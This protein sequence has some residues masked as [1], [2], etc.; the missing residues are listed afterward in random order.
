MYIVLSILAELFFVSLL[1]F[2]FYR[3]KPRFGLAPLYILLGANQYFQTI[4]A[5]SFYIKLFGELSI[6]PGNIILFSSSLFAILFIYIKE[7]ERST[8]VL[9]MGI[10]LANL[11]IT[12][13]ASITHLQETVM[14]DIINSS[15]TVPDFFNT[16]FRIFFVGNVTLIMDAFIMVILYEFFFTKVRRLKLFTR[17]LITMLVVLNFDAVV[18]VLGS[19]WGSTDLWNQVASQLIGK[20]VVAMFFATVLWLYLRYLDNDRKNYDEYPRK[21]GNEDIFSILTYKG[22]LEKLQ[23]EKTISDEQLQKSITDKTEELQNSVRRFIILSSVHEL[24]MDKSSSAEQAREFLKKIRE[25]FEID[26]CTIHLLKD[27]EL[28]MLSNVGIEKNE[29]EEILVST[30]PYFKEI[31][32]KKKCL[33]IEDTRKNQDWVK[34]REMGLIKFNYLSCLG[35]PLLSGNKVIGVIKLYSRIVKRVFTAIE[36]EHFQS[37]ARQV[38]HT[39]ENAQLYEQNEKHKEV[40]VRQIIAR[41]KAVEET[42]KSIQRFELIGKAANDAVWEWNLE[43]SEFWSN[44]IHMN[45]YGLTKADPEPGDGEWKRRL[46]DEDRERMLQTIDNA[47]ASDV[48]SFDA[49]YRLYTENKGWRTIYGRNYIERN[50]EGKAI[51]M[52]GSMMDITERKKAETE[53]QKLATIVQRSPEFIGIAGLDAK[54]IYLN[55]GGK[56]M[57]GLDADIT[58]TSMWDYFAPPDLEIFQTKALP[59]I[60]KA[61]RWVGDINLKNFQT[62]E[63]IPVWMDI[64][65]IFHQQ[66][67]EPIA[68][69]T[70]TTDITERKKT[71]AAMLQVNERNELIS[72]ATNDA[73]WDW[74]LTTNNV[75]WN[76]GVTQLFGHI[77]N[78]NITTPDWWLENIH[79]DEREKVE[80]FFFD[81]VNGKADFWEDEYRF[82]C[83]DGTYKNVYDRGLVRRDE[84]GKAF[85]ML[86]AMMDITDRKKAEEEL[87]TTNERLLFHLDNSPLG[88]IE[89]DKNF[90]VR[91][92]SKRTEEIFGWTEKEFIEKQKNGFS[93][94]YEE[95]ISELTVIAKQLMEGTVARNHIIHRNYTLSGKVIWCEW[96]N[97]VLKDEDGNVIA[98]MSLVKDITERKAVEEK[99]K[100]TTEQLHQLTAHLQTIREEE[101]KKIGRE[102][103]D[104]LGQQLTAIK[105]DT[106]WIDKQIPADT[107][108]IKDKLQ[109]ILTLLNGSHQSVRKI[110]N[111]LRPAVLDDNGLLEAL[112]W[113]GRQFSESTGIPMHFSSNQNS[114][115][116]PQETATCIFRVYQES[117][118]NIMRY[119]GAGEVVSSLNTVNDRII[120]SIEDDGKGFDV[121]AVQSKKSF[122]LLGMKERVHSLNGRIDLV[123]SP[124]NGT[125]I[126]ISLPYKNT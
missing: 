92:W 13:L 39:I 27:E 109:N 52:L 90:F 89:W 44:E 5:S 101:R 108:A 119:A 99:I 19:F 113:Q 117:L 56:K 48:N 116:L 85:R 69:A 70:V 88:Y 105:M 65:Y 43:T 1:M 11:S 8:Q 33:A 64:F 107:I 118:T 68:F 6:S 120:L 20:S 58:T 104:E 22:K 41:K 45:L 112:Q 4:L 115:K 16:S 24:R 98:I 86:G 53:I 95:D 66:T 111:E 106:V 49:E 83:S 82:R 14:Q 36:I 7:G 29:E 94:I 32:G 79:T 59:A 76:P 28:R 91:T 37:V 25:A 3:L 60:Q 18:F 74:D 100:Y 50:A 67:N 84:N 81:L 102:I 110:L 40:L 21:K 77:F 35:A 62:G 75:W 61:G 12:L 125:K 97:S 78:N 54:V 71:E 87:K 34:G 42:I 122:G 57:V 126:I 2:L 73:L 15:G 46:H 80:K 72:Q 31:I 96:F 51:R 103:H 17:L 121:E 30:T 124:G 26:A 93:L 9:I 10:V 23:I 114:I 63:L 47:L 123:S 55:E 38:A